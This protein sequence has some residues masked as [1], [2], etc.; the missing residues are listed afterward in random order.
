MK[1][2]SDDEADL[3]KSND[4]DFCFPKIAKVN[5][6]VDSN[7]GI[8]ESQEKM[9]DRKSENVPAPYQHLSNQ[10]DY[11]DMPQKSNIFRQHAKYNESNAKTNQKVEHENKTKVKN[12]TEVSQNNTSTNNQVSWAHQDWNT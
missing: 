12:Q 1:K 7:A 11:S 8:K 9:Q 5:K 10:V 6:P 4:D 3:N 2:N